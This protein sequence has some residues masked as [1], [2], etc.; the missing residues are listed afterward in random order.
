MKRELKK[1]I[2]LEAQ[3]KGYH[4]HIKD[5]DKTLFDDFWELMETVN[6]H[7]D[8]DNEEYIEIID[9]LI[10]V[11]HV[12]VGDYYIIVDN[13]NADNLEI[14]RETKRQLLEEKESKKMKKHNN[15]L[16]GVCYHCGSP[17][18]Y[19]EDAEIVDTYVKYNYECDE[20]HATGVE[21]YEMVFIENKPK[22]ND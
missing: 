13:Y 11:G 9:M 18:I 22:Y 10:M 8:V 6:Y 4:G 2:Y 19:Y 1:V 20:C 16:Q 3:I 12:V 17:D 21:W 5:I 15:D 7:F 14:L